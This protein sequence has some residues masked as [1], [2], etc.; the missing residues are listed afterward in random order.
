MR[1]GKLSDQ[2]KVQR[3]AWFEQYPKLK[4]ACDLKKAFCR[5]CNCKG[6]IEAERIFH[7]W[8]M[9]IPIDRD[10]IYWGANSVIRSIANSG[11]G[12][13]FAVMRGKVLLT[14][15]RKV[16]EPNGSKAMRDYGAP[17]E[18]IL[19]AIKKRCISGYPPL[20]WQRPLQDTFRNYYE[21]MI[22]NEIYRVILSIIKTVRKKN[23]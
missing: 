18:G 1:E 6:R 8:Y 13:D 3:D 19:E 23:C 5:I 21:G 20:N 9:S 7:E 2:G 14:A 12:Y 10:Y 4:I 16:E 15:G 11:R 22:Y 17:S